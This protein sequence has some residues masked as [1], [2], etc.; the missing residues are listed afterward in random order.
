[1]KDIKEDIFDNFSEN[2][3]FNENK[4]NIDENDF[5]QKDIQ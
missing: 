4:I 3:D 2:K 5:T 1:M